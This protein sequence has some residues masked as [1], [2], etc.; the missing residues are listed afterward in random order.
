MLAHKTATIDLSKA[1]GSR[2][3]WDKPKPVVYLWAVAERL[4]VT[5]SWQISSA[6][7]VKVLRLFGARIGEGVIFR[8]RTRVGFPWKL[9]I[10][11]RSWIGEGVWIHNQ[12]QVRIGHDAVIS[13][14]TFLTTGSHAHRR[15]MALI[16]SPISIGDGAWV[17]SRCVVLGGADVGDNALVS[18]QSVVKGSVPPNTIAG[19]NPLAFLG[20]RFPADGR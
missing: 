17:T 13:Q 16:T 3:A 19:G 20:P 10:G 5:N 2:E 6:L 9:E 7:R 15:D 8:P 12:D 18:P 1:P 4:F 11:D 14:E